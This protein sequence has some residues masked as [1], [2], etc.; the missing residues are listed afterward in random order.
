MSRFIV[1]RLIV[2]LAL[3]ALL[4]SPAVSLAASR[5]TAARH[6]RAQAAAQ[7]PLSWLWNALVSVWEK[8]GCRIDPNGQ[9]LVNLQENADTGCSLEPYG[10]CVPGS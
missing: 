4:G 5:S 8:E 1:R 9:C 10:R 2:V 7:A 3:S 6:S